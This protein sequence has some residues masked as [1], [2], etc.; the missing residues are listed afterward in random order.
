MSR[1]RAAE[2]PAPVVL[3]TCEHGGNTV[4]AAYRALFA[5]QAR[6]L[7]SHE[8]YDI[9][10]LAA[11]RALA[12]RWRV[13][14]VAGTVS[15]LLVDLNRSPAHPRLLSA[16]TRTLVAPE[17]ERLLA[18][19]YHPYRG[20]VHGWIAAR[21]GRGERVVHLSVHSFVPRLNGQR[22][23]CDLGLLYDP[24][25]TDEAALCRD[26]QAA[27][28]DWAVRRNFPYRGTSDGQVVSLR[29]AF[30]AGAYVGIEIELNQGLLR[31]PARARQLV[32]DLALT[33]PV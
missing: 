21:V 23:D 20:L 27:L 28:G 29:R 16:L 25:R 13:P 14:L 12:R 30:P 9:G 7:A 24:S 32:A 19:H 8:G 15:R 4:P 2:R 1:R 31:S 6:R 18:R 22:R 10:A 11:A 5:G 33:L 17:R 3:L 26:W